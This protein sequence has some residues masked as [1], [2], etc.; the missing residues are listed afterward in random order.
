MKQQPHKMVKLADELFEYV[1][2]FCG[3]GA[4]RVKIPKFSILVILQAVFDKNNTVINIYLARLFLIKTLNQI[5]FGNFNGLTKRLTYFVLI[6]IIT[7]WLV[8]DI[9]LIPILSLFDF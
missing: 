3:A 2:P 7:I 9:F 5:I 1:W 6:S 4:E 8:P